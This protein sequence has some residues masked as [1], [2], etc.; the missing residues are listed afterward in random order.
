L[1]SGGDKEGAFRDAGIEVSTM[2][3][4]TKFEFHPKL[5][6][7]AVMLAGSLKRKGIDI[8][9][10]HTRVTQVMAS[11]ISGLSGIPFVSTCHGFFRADRISRR[12]FPAWG[13]GVIA[14]SGPV[15]EHLVNDFKLSPERVVIVRNGIDAELYSQDMSEDEKKRTLND[16]G[17]A[18]HPVIGTV[19]RLSPVKGH[20]FLIRAFGEVRSE[21]PEARLIIVGEGSYG[22][23]LRKEA[24]RSG[25]SDSVVFV[26]TMPD[27]KAVLKLLDVYVFPS[28]QE[29]LGFSLL[30][31][32]AS[33]LPCVATDTGGIRDVIDDGNEGVLV[34]PGDEK[35]LARAIIRVVKDRQL[36]SKLAENGR[37]K[38]RNGFSLDIMAEQT[39]SFYRKVL[40]EK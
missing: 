11:I 17:A 5:F 34:S 36:G 20:E 28:I 8:I 39:I 29:G 30:E 26:K 37:N 7:A 25:Q 4:K 23:I 13:R 21:F 35:E 24:E 1:S 16:L 9:H 3:I 10:A 38:V 32:M 22:D 15:R 33:G 18:G 19:G 31:A 6:A 40:N 27:I 12:V 2:D 14:I